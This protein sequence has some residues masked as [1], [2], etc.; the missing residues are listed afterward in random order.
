MAAPHRKGAAAMSDT[1][2][3]YVC[4]RCHG[5]NGD[6]DADNGCDGAST[7]W[8]SGVEN[9]ANANGQ[10]GTTAAGVR[11]LQRMFGG[12]QERLHSSLAARTAAS[13]PALASSPASL[14]G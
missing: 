14:P 9:A 8:I 7:R 10:R 5:A 1:I 11:L 13:A 6:R 4:P 12:V 2:M 3:P